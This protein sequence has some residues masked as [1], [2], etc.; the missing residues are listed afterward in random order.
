MKYRLSLR[1]ILRAKPT[2]FPEG[3]GY[4]SSHVLTRVS[5]QTLSI[6]NPINTG[7]VDSPYC[8]DSWAIWENI[9]KYIE[10]Y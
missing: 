5:I 8:F 4:I 1:E 2:G 9:A 3:S 7:R 6:T 10:Q